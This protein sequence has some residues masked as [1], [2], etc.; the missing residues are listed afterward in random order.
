[1][2]L[3]I[4]IFIA[5]MML[6]GAAKADLFRI[7]ATDDPVTRQVT[8]V[9]KELYRRLGHDVVFTFLP[10]KRS[11]REV[12]SGKYD[13]ELLR[14]T[15]FE[16]K[17]PN[18]IRMTEPLYS[19]SVSAIVRVDSNIK[20]ATWDSLKK[21]KVVYP[22][23]YKLL[24]IRLREHT[25]HKVSNTKLIPTMVAKGRVDVGIMIT[26]TAKKAVESIKGLMVLSP[27]LETVTL[28]HYLNV[29]HR[30]LI[31]SLEKTLIEMNDSGLSTKFLSTTD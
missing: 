29:K 27:P 23:G 9:A 11:I 24:D 6:T 28:Y 8:K 31:P 18:L 20:N 10:A 14:S 4:S 12:N 15:G 25:T 3:V 17:F 22:L 21:Y 26:H 5:F 13:A 1:M 30:R 2:R 16:N 7:A 19:V